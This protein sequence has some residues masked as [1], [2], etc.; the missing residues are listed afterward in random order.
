MVVMRVVTKAEMKVVRK[1]VE[2][3]DKMAEMMVG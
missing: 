1:A 2:M 3:V